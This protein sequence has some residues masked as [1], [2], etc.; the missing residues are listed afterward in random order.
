M[1]LFTFS[2]HN[3]YVGR[4][5][6]TYRQEEWGGRRGEGVGS[7]DKEEEEGGEE[8]KEKEEIIKLRDTYMTATYTQT[9]WQ[10]QVS[11][12]L[13]VSGYHYIGML[14]LKLT[15]ESSC[16]RSHQKGTR[17]DIQRSVG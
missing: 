14:Y 12:S 9:V 1:Y 2:D 6:N 7:E 8:E 10:G 5:P 13:S 17:N 16:P 15:S 4:V 11:D 3:A